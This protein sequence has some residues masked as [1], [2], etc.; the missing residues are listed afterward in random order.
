[1]LC[2]LS[3]IV[4]PPAYSESVIAF[5]PHGIQLET[6][7]GLP[8]RPLT[9][10]RRFIPLT[11][12][13][14]FII[15]EGLRR[16]NVRFYLA[17]MLRDANDNFSLHV[18]YE[19]TSCC[20][21]YALIQLKSNCAR[22]SCHTSLYFS[23][24]TEAFTRPCLMYQELQTTRT[25]DFFLILSSTVHSA[26]HPHSAPTN[27]SVNSQALPSKERGMKSLTATESHALFLLRLD[28]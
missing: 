11:M 28:L 13:E 14:D 15:N 17:A 21:K 4:T 2:R 8:S 26:R 18:A 1:M 23:R 3:G 12:L 20:P 5:P 25:N 16:W 22:T 9:T 6:H 7:R 27:F 10:S 19:V 24:Y